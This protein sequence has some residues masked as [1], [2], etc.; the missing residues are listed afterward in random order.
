MIG[1]T[2]II[3]TVISRQH[4]SQVDNFAYDSYRSYYIRIKEVASEVKNRQVRL[5]T[6]EFE[7]PVEIETYARRL[8]KGESYAQLNAMVNELLRIFGTYQ[9]DG[10][11]G[12]QGITLDRISSMEKER[13]P[14]QTTWARKL[15]IILHYY[16]VSV[17]G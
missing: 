17:V 16:K 10:I 4:Q 14:A 13:P 15:R 9:E 3:T 1:Q 12:V 6:Y 7:T 2:P 5:N 11:F 8:S